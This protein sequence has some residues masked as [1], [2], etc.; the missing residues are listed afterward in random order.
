MFMQLVRQHIFRQGSSLNKMDSILAKLENELNNVRLNARVSLIVLP[1]TFYLILIAMIISFVSYNEYQENRKIKELAFFSTHVGS[2][3]HELQRERGLTSGYVG[4]REKKEFE[5][6]LHVQKRKTDRALIKFQ[7]FL[8][9]SDFHKLGEKFVNKTLDANKMIQNLTNVREGVQSDNIIY[10]NV[11]GE[12]S[13]IIDNFLGIISLMSHIG[14]N[15]DV[16]RAISAY[17][18][19]MDIKE[20]VGLERAVGVQALTRRNFDVDEYYQF[21]EY[22]AIEQAFERKFIMVASPAIL[23]I[24]N[25]NKIIRIEIDAEIKK[26]REIVISNL[27]SLEDIDYTAELWYKALTLKIDYLKDIEDSLNERIVQ[28]AQNNS[29]VALSRVIRIIVLSIF[30][31]GIL[32]FISTIIAKS[33]SRPMVALNKA[34]KQLAQGNMSGEVPFLG[35]KSEFGEM[36]AVMKE[37]I[38][39]RNMIENLRKTLNSHSLITIADVRGKIIYA[40][41]KFIQSSGFSLNEIINHSHNI[42]TSDYH[43]PEFYSE[44]WQDISQGRVW[45]GVICNKTKEG[46]IIWL[47]TTIVPFVG[48][49]GKPF[50]YVS[51][52][53]NITKLKENEVELKKARKMAMISND[54][55][56][57]FL[58]T[59]SHE[60][61]TPLNHILGYSDLIKN[62]ALGPIENKKYLEYSNFIH[63]SGMNLLDI[64]NDILDLSCIDENGLQASMELIDIH[65]LVKFELVPWH[66]KQAAN[67]GNQLV[68]SIGQDLPNFYADW[69]YLLKMLKHIISNAMKFSEKNS[70]VSLQVHSDENNA[71]IFKI[72]DQGIGMSPS[73]LEK[74]KHPFEMKDNSNERKYP[75]LGAGLTISKAIVDIH[76]GHMEIYTK[77]G[78]GTLIVISFPRQ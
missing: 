26:F 73:D 56:T 47:L 72:Q 15:V 61:R 36:A 18:A 57:R 9:N 3:I 10:S 33:I 11:I 76:G 23:R 78:E 38:A 30:S 2:I 4:A 12:Y 46:E 71:M 13:A 70:D 64:I 53:T 21:L 44:M 58:A 22:I 42:F 14:S 29:S 51:I 66:K 35:F 55:K 28:I 39:S 16:N 31:I 77:L 48:E 63:D 59:T 6:L 45:K 40:N 17:F 20:R 34:M 68:L 27:G 41:D 67:N 1:P 69:D 75:G 74:V 19:I 32:F 7:T 37:S 5:L 54:A 24:Y 50:Q 8:K 62:Q 43:P 49:N 65:Q 25:E 60:L 52:R